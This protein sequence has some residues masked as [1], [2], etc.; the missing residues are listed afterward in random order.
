MLDLGNKCSKAEMVVARQLPQRGK[1]NPTTCMTADDSALIPTSRIAG[2]CKAVESH[3]LVETVHILIV[4]S[5]G[6][7]RYLAGMTVT[8]FTV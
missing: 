2:R 8:T 6:M 3:P 5:R 7:Q 1:L 4:E